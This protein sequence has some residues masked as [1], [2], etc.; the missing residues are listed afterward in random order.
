MTKMAR[1]LH[2]KNLKMTSQ[3]IAIIN[4]FSADCGPMNAETI[5]FK[6]KSKKINLVTIYRNLASLEKAGILKR[7]DLHEDSIYYEL[8]DGHHHHIICT[9]CGTI[10]SFD[11]CAID[12]LSSKLLSRSSKFKEISEHSLELFGL[13]KK[14]GPA[15]KGKSR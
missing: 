9:D 11:N 4:I 15:L 5:F 8:A 6:L 3:R 14:C 12:R 2:E 10:E 13:C 7:I 1:L